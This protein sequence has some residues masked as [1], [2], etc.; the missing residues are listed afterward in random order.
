TIELKIKP[1]A[2]CK[3]AREKELKKL[4]EN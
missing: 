3:L 4:L 2:E 1:P